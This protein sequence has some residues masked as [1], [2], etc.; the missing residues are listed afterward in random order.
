MSVSQRITK[1][2]EELGFSQSELARRAG[3]KPP[4]ISQ[5]E[6][7]ARTPSYEAVIK[8][9]NALNLSADY[10]MSGKE[11]NSDII[12]DK[13]VQLLLKIIENFS[14][15]QKESLLEYAKFLGKYYKNEDIQLLN[16]SNEYATFI[17]KKYSDN[18][19]PVDVSSIAN[20]LNITVYESDLGEHGEGMLLNEKDKIIIINSAIKNKQRKKFTIAVLLGHAIIPWHIKSTYEIRKKGTSTMLVE[21]IEEMEAQ[22]FAASLIMPLD[23]IQKDFIKTNATIENLKELAG[24][25]YDVSLFALLNR[26]VSSASDKYAVVQSGDW[27]IIKTHQGNRPLI[28]KVSHNSIAS[29]FFDNPSEVEEIRQGTVLASCWLIDANDDETIYEESIYNPVYGK[30]L[31]LLTMN[32]NK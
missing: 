16:D 30:V 10:L 17:L 2:R 6:S 1:R 11:V 8:L 15:D 31:T 5:Y 32:S 14:I 28:E 18:S 29:T 9:S 24:E 21:D 4:A 13:T 7:G 23:Q 20:Q 27:N 25:K 12:S 3:L 19:I 22:N 26:L